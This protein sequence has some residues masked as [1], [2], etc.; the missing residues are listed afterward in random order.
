MFGMLLA[1]NPRF[2]LPNL[3]HA[4]DAVGAPGSGSRVSWGRASDARC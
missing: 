1:T 2:E 3:A 4:L